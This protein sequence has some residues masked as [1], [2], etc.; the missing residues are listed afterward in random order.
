MDSVFDFAGRNIAVKID[1]QGHELAA[2]KGMANLLS[3]NKA[4][5]QVE[6]EEENTHSL[7]YL[8]QSGFRC[9]HY[10]GWDFYF[11]NDGRAE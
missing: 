7:N 1:V 8:I 6:I 2:L 4:F 10:I 11:A 3:R 9:T 5:L